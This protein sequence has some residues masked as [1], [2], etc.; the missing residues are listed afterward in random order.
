VAARAYTF[1]SV[2]SQLW[3][4]L[5]GSSLIKALPLQAFVIAFAARPFPVLLYR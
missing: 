3:E 1:R 5:H 2:R 4:P